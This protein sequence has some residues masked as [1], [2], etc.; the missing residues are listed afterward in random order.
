MDKA[1]IEQNASDVVRAHGAPPSEKE[2]DP[3][4]LR[5]LAYRLVKDDACLVVAE[6]IAQTKAINEPSGGAGAAGNGGYA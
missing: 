2:D 6:I 4:H 1:Q 3:E 5:Q